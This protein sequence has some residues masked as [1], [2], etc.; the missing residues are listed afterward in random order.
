[1]KISATLRTDRLRPGAVLSGVFSG[2]EKNGANAFQDKA[3]KNFVLGLAKARRFSGKENG[4]FF[5]G[6][7]GEAKNGILISG[8]GEKKKFSADKL[9]K[10][11]SALYSKLNDLKFENAS[12][13]LD[14]LTGN[15]VSSPEAAAALVEGIRLR[16]YRFDHY[17]SK[18]DKNGKQDT[19]KEIILA[20]SDRKVLEA[21]SKELGMA[22]VV[23]E[24]ANFTRRLGDEPANVM[25]ARRLADDARKMARETGLRCRILDEKQIRALKMGGLLSVAQ[26]SKEP[27]RFIILEHRGAAGQPVVLVGKGICFDS[28]GISLKPAGGMDL[29]RYDM[30]GGAAVI[31]ILR[32]AAK[33]KLKQH[34]VG[35]VPACENLPSETPQRPGDI[36][37]TLSGKTVEVLNTD[38]EGRLILCDALTYAHRYKPRVIIDLATLT[39]ACVATFG[40]VCMGMM[41]NDAG[42]LKMI[43]KAGYETGEKCWEL[44]LWEEYGE[45]VKSPVADLKNIGGKYAGT[46]TAGKF[47]EAFVDDFPW[48]HLDIAGV[49][50][51]ESPAYYAKS[52]AT[53]AGVRLIVRYLRNLAKHS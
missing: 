9:R 21:V 3:V 11:G 44:P 51:R 46:I 10:L 28:G 8:L 34:V 24:S 14:T 38:A 22:E 36:Q 47:L 13:E 37:R 26:G 52:G 30:C 2:E 5:T 29:M 1:M 20:I 6:V 18:D 48:C 15:K 40:D 27:P 31:G 12:V 53:G 42:L 39:G 4:L 49:A 23:V 17:K 32:A 41:G 25:T 50:W 7:P 45:M 16:E 33:L 19:L 43:Q 35:L